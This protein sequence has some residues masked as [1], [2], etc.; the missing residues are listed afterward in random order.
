MKLQKQVSR[1]VEDREYSKYVVVV[2][3]DEVERLGWKEG[4]E[5]EHEVKEQTLL[6]HP[7]RKARVAQGSR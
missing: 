2:P 5:L 4:Q 7:S 1:R 3:P 6:I